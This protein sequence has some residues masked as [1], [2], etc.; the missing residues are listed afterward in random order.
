MDEESECYICTD[1]T[2]ERSPCDC[3]HPVHL[4]C[5][6]Q[7]V[8]KNDN[9]GINCS[10]CHTKLQDIELPQRPAEISPVITVPRYRASRAYTYTCTRLLFFLSCGYFGKFLFAVSFDPSWLSV[11]DYWTP[12]DLIFMVCACA[13]SAFVIGWL[14]CTA[15]FLA[16][17]S[18]TDSQH[19]EEFNDSG[20]DSD[21]SGLSIV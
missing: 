10:I 16:Y 14:K 8:K 3:A 4:K 2:E 9:M 15:K 13:I 1:P 21:G 18:R 7:W 5:L 12:F 6:M 20:S 11:D 19:Y 17:I